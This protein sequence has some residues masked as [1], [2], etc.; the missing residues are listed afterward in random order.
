MFSETVD[1]GFMLLRI[2]APAMYYKHSKNALQNQVQRVYQ[3]NAVG[4]INVGAK[5]I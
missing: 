3:R 4:F 2:I 5:R 1:G